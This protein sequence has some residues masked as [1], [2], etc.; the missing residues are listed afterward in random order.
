VPEQQQW[1]LGGISSLHA[2]VPGVAVGDSGLL[3]RLSG[4]RVL[5]DHA[6][7][8]LRLRGF[9]EYG[10]ARYAQDEAPRPAGGTQALADAGAEVVLGCKPYLEMALTAAAPWFDQGVQPSVLSE[11]RSHF[12]F[13]LTAR[14]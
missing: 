3:L 8:N 14:F 10:A 1:V 11:T 12:F 7:W 9:L 13:R 5:L 2:Y 4:E 6:R